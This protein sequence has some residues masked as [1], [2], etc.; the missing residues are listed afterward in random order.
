MERRKFIKSIGAL[1]AIGAIPYRAKA[2]KFTLPI[3]V[4][5]WA[6]NI[7]A[8][9]AAWDVLKQN[10]Y[11]LDAVEAGVKIPEA[12]PNDRSVGYGGNPDR[13]GIV[14]L[15]A[16]IMNEKHG[17]GS[18]MAMEEIMH[19]ISVAR[20]VMEKTPHVQL[21]GKGAQQFAM[22]NGFKKQNL[23]TPESE[24]AWKQ[25][26]LTSNYNPMTTVE[27]LH[28]RNK[29]SIW[30]AKKI[31]ET[32]HDTIGMLAIDSSNKICGAC[33]TSGM[34]YKMHGRV[35]DSPI[36]GAG[37]FVDNKVGAATSSGVGEEVVRTCGSH[38]VIL[39]ME[40]GYSP[41]NACKKAVEKIVAIHGE[42]KAKRLQVGYIAISK[43]GE[44]GA[45]AI[46]KGFNYVVT[47]R[48]GNQTFESK[49]LFE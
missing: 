1:S 29:K 18:V 3:V 14:T 42:E 19:A 6:A 13:D 23:L 25:W 45:Y 44:V 32:Q 43:N 34:A 4:S 27:E 30:P 15:D 40:H 41:E 16:C 21:V 39:Y 33:T 46:K 7:K 9:E 49:Y 35:G 8:N 11:A 22:E 20:L 48:N 26:L 28:K 10:G 17:I 38:T 36:I 2:E 24:K 37:L 12:D 31:D 47:N 5:T